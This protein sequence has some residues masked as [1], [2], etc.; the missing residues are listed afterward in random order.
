GVRIE[1][2]TFGKPDAPALLLIM[3]LGGQM[4]Y[5]DEEFC[6][7]LAA[8]GHHVI[9]FDNRDVGLSTHFDHAGVPSSIDAKE[10]R[11]GASSRIPYTLEDMADDAFGLLDALHIGRAH[12]FGTSMGGMIAQ[13]MALSRPARLLSLISMSSSTGNPGLS[14]LKAEDPGVTVEPEPMEREANIDFTVRGLGMLA[15]RGFPFDEEG[16]RILVA[17]A[18]DRAFYPEGRWRQLAAVI[19]APSRKEALASLKIPTLVIHGDDDVLVP[20]AHGKDTAES[21]PDADLLVIA[22]MGHDLP[23]QVWPRIV[24]AVAA[25]TT[26]AGQLQS[27]SAQ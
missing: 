20:L 6:A 18:Y 19:A 17:R 25:H 3:G 10:A 5:W 9:R 27:R 26:R 4:I 24:S 16:V 11:K 15:G 14:F 2:D 12:V 21:I 7:Q 8:S 13:I 23:R 1:Y 22:G